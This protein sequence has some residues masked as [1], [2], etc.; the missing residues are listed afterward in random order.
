[1]LILTVS[2]RNR[3]S[4]PPPHPECLCK[5]KA[6]DGFYINKWCEH[7]K[8]L[9]LWSGR[10]FS[11][12]ARSGMGGEEE[13]IQSCLRMGGQMGVCTIGGDS[14]MLESGCCPIAHPAVCRSALHKPTCS[15]E[16][17]WNIFFL[18]AGFIYLFF[19]IVSF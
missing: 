6:G 15:S 4:P 14:W 3:R 2:N 9:W 17:D 11:K 1:M 10:G 7:A 12:K 19:L 16:T 18:F 5:S 13:L 8:F